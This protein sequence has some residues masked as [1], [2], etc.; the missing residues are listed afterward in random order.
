MRKFFAFPSK[1]EYS[2]KNTQTLL[3]IYK[4]NADL[5]EGTHEN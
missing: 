2:Y 5:A 3:Q 4:K 1:S